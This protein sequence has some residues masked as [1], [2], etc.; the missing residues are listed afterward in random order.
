VSPGGCSCVYAR[1]EGG[2]GG[3]P[4]AKS[5]KENRQAEGGKKERKHT[6]QGRDGRMTPRRHPPRMDFKERSVV[7][8]VTQGRIHVLVLVHVHAE[9]S[10][11]MWEH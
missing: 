4:A 10:M 8:A 9:S 5:K 2:L 11:C 6:S 1:K 7:L 3:L